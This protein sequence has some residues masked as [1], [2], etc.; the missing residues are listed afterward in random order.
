M[1]QQPATRSASAQ[2]RS[3]RTISSGR[4]AAALS[5][6]SDASNSA[7]CASAAFGGLGEHSP[8]LVGP[9]QRAHRRAP[10]AVQP[11]SGSPGRAGSLRRVA[12]LGRRG[13][14][15]RGL[16]DAGLAA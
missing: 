14:D 11:R 1:V 6:A 12:D 4:C 10:D 5:S 15:E 3:S 2:W 8:Q 9:D 7:S 16:T 13:V